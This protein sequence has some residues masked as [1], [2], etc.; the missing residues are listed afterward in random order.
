MPPGPDAAD[1]ARKAVRLDPGS[2]HAHLVLGLTLE[3]EKRYAEALDV[4]EEALRLAVG[5]AGLRLQIHQEAANVLLELGR[6]GPAGEQARAAI[7]LAPGN[8]HAHFVLGLALERE[9]RYEEALAALEEALERGRS[10]PGLPAQIRVERAHIFLEQ[11]R[12]DLSVA[13]TRAALAQ[14]APAGPAALS[15]AA[16]HRAAGRQAEAIAELDRALERCGGDRRLNARI[17]NEKGHILFAQAEYGP[18]IAEFRAA[19]GA[20]ER[21]GNSLFLLG[22][23]CKHAGRPEE[24]LAALEGALEDAARDPGLRAQI[25]FEAAHI[26]LGLGQPGP[27]AERAREALRLDPGN[28]HAQLVLGLAL[29]REGRCDEALAAL[30]RA[31]E[32]GQDDGELRLRAREERARVLRGQ[33]RWDEALAELDQALDLCG[34]DPQRGARVRGE[35]ADILFSQGRHESAI[36][37]FRAAAEAG[38]RSGGASLLLGLACLRAGRPEEALAALDEALALSGDD[39]RLRSRIHEARADLLFARGEPAPALDEFGRALELCGGASGVRTRLRE[40]RARIL[41]ER[42]DCAAA[43]RELEEADGRSA[44][45]GFMLGQS[46]QRAGQDERA[47]AAFDEALRLGSGDR[48]LLGRI[49]HERARIHSRQGRDDLAREGFSEAVA[50]GHDTEEAHLL[51]ARGHVKRGEWPRAEAEFHEAVRMNPSKQ[52]LREL[53]QLYT[54]LKK[55]DSCAAACARYLEVEA[56]EDAAENRAL[57]DRLRTLGAG[58]RPDR[59][60]RVKLIRTPFFEPPLN[61]ALNY[62]LL[63]PLGMSTITAYLRANGIAVDQDDLHVRIN[64]RN[65]FGG[66]GGTIPADLFRDEARM[67]AYVGGEADPGLEAAL[68][69]VEALSPCAGYDVVVLSLIGDDVNPSETLFTLAFSRRLKTRHGPLILVGGAGREIDSLAERDTPHIDY[70]G[71]DRGEKML[72]LLLTALRHGVDLAEVPDPPIQRSGK[73]LQAGPDAIRFW[74]DPDYAGLPL[75]LYGYRSPRRLDCAD[76]ELRE[77]LGGFAECG[78]RAAQWRLMEGCFFACIFCG[79]SLTREV[80]VLP[81]RQAAAQLRRLREEHGIRCF[82]FVDRM[83]N[84]SRRYVNEF[85]DELLREGLDIL[86]SD[87]ARADNLDRETLLK[88]R[89]AGCVRLIYG[90]ETA[91]PRL[92]KLIDKRIDLGRLEDTLRWTDEAGI[93]TGLEL[94][95]G[96]P[97]ETREDVQA[98]VDFLRRNQARI[99]ML[100][101]T[102]L[103]LEKMS[104]LYSDPAGFGVANVAKFGPD[105]APPLGSMSDFKFD[106][107]GGLPWSEKRRA[108]EADFQYLRE[109]TRDIGFRLPTYEAEHLIFYLYSRLGDKKKIA[110]VLKRAAA[111]L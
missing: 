92:L 78:L 85:C 34:G 35:R 58:R 108:T 3:R 39:Q 40:A 52:T 48:R 89:R 74:T 44:S 72:F 73:V 63:P 55:A 4:L 100:Y 82:F 111:V 59:P 67:L 94:I 76:A 23:A 107:A 95:S 7:R 62:S 81:P 49:H 12:F 30:G 109:Q 6:P 31:L 15:L 101:Y 33:G 105:D 51:L 54:K 53:M 80:L 2:G 5:D 96:F 71:K 9:K 45:A 24:A 68:D 1:E 10:E 21:S 47:L 18:A 26:L 50:L 36:A 93:L 14:G 20:G 98:T 56:A 27:A 65:A 91:S 75:D 88:M 70:I 38:E 28:G 106:E 103:Y 66:S 16:A 69:Q 102:T 99:D 29:G 83:I 110:S 97:S 64:H 43:I 37:E 22:L 90:L 11:G 41:F 17:R 32:L 86:W 79:A 46:Y 25:H 104:R 42:G 19:V 60:L 8:G 77:L 61:G 84:V 87:C 13:E 57:R